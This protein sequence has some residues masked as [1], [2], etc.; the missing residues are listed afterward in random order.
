VVYFAK[1]P[2]PGHVKTRLV[3]PLTPVEAAALYGA[4]LRQ[5]VVPIAGAHTYLYGWPAERLAEFSDYIQSGIELRP[6]CGENL[7]AR[8]ITCFDQ[9]FA[10]GH[11]PVLIRNTDSPD[12]PVAVVVEALRRCR[13]G[14]AVLGP[15]EGGGYYLVA[16]SERQPEL[17]APS[18]G[19]DEGQYERA[20]QRARDLG[21]AVET[22]PRHRDVDSYDDLL[23]M[24]RAR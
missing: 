22:L 23:A 24:W 17:F 11:S 7:F 16:L 18:A 13:P 21:L 15:D 14:T 10:A 9:L 19:A 8:I 1:L 3:P 6:Q 5:S 4:F 2:V 20:A 12:L